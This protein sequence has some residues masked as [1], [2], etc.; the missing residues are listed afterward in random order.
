MALSSP[1]EVFRQAWID[2]VRR[3]YP[4]EPK[5][6]YITPW[7]AMPEWERD[8]A[9]AVYQQIR[10]FVLATDGRTSRLGR[11]Q[12]GRFVAICWTGQ[13]FKHIPDPK[14][15]YVADWSELPDWQRE[16]DADIFDRVESDINP[17]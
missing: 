11:E 8:S 9:T 4:G 7:Q 5:P 14:P 6:S 2:G 12:R 1:G 15:A 16:T 17:D 3:H 10:D 13:V